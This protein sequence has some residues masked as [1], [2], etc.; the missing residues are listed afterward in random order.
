MHADECLKFLV[1][2]VR[3]C[4]HCPPDR[5]IFRTII[6]NWY[7]LRRG[8]LFV[9]KSGKPRWF[10]NPKLRDHPRLR[11]M[12]FISAGAGVVLDGHSDERLIVDHAVPVRHIH[13]QLLELPQ[14]VGAI[15]SFL[16]AN[17]RL[18]V[19]TKKEDITLND[20]ELKSE[21]PKDWDGKNLF[22]RYEAVGIV[23]AFS[24][25]RP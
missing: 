8:G 5:H 3:Y 18:G 7:A 9:Y 15:E 23:Q 17:Y 10:N 4:D 6:D 11:L 19:L 13:D 14:D 21:M 24:G 12:D 16:L 22:A 2:Y 25:A 20:N 1:A